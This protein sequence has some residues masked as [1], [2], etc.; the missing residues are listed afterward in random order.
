MKKTIFLFIALAGLGLSSCKKCVTCSNC[1]LGTNVG[2]ICEKNY[3]SKADYDN[4]VNA[5]K[6][7]LGC[8]CKSKICV[9]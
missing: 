8:T 1:A 2:E 4:A 6:N 5:A 3:S 9:K 7:N